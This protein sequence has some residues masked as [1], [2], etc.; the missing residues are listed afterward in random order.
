LHR[1][2]PRIV[3]GLEILA[4]LLHPDLFGEFL[5]QAGQLYCRVTT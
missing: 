5:P 1:P 4:G 2:G 3:E